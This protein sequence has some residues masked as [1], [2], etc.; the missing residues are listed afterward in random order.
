MRAVGA[1]A[2]P[3]TH[4]AARID[5]Q[6]RIVFGTHHFTAKANMARLVALNVLAVRTAP[7][8]AVA[9][10]AGLGGPRLDARQMR[11]QMTSGTRPHL[12]L[13]PNDRDTNDAFIRASFEFTSKILV[14][15]RALFFFSRRC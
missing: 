8:T 6:I 2:R 1:N 15:F 10:C 5:H 13:F 9:F 3:L 11:H 4:L 7:R 14:Q 12:G